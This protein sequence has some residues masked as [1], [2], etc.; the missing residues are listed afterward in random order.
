MPF[1]KFVT[2]GKHL[3]ILFKI[4][5]GNSYWKNQFKKTTLKHTYS[6]TLCLLK[7]CIFAEVTYDVPSWGVG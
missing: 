7:E 3:L 5:G 2:S 4:V 1:I 6:I